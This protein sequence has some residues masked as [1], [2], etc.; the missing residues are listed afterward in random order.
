M[1]E[2]LEILSVLFHELVLLFKNIRVYGLHL[3]VVHFEVA[4]V[5]HQVEG[6]VRQTESSFSVTAVGACAGPALATVVLTFCEGVFL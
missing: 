4:Y 1:S 2:C 5:A 3:V 6:P